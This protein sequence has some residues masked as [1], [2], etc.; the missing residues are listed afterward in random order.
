MICWASNGKW[1]LPVV[2]VVPFLQIHCE[3]QIRYPKF[4]T[5][6]SSVGLNGYGLLTSTEI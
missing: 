1:S 4:N 6:G 3:I 2:A 5:H